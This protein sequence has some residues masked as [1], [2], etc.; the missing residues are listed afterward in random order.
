[1]MIHAAAGVNGGV[2]V[3]QGTRKVP[4]LLLFFL[5]FYCKALCITFDSFDHLD[6]NLANRIQPLLKR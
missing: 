4:P 1:M 3:M 2:R 5:K 6:I